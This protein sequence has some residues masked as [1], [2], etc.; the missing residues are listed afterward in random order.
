MNTS[1]SYVSRYPRACTGCL[2]LQ[3]HAELTSILFA[4]MSN[5]VRYN[6]FIHANATDKVT[7]RP[8]NVLFPVNLT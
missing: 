2:L 8:N 1:P 5:V 4:L 7:W 3:L 6:L